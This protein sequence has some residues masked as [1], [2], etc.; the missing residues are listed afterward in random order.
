MIAHCAPQY[1]TKDIWR[2]SAPA[3]ILIACIIQVHSLVFVQTT[4]GKMI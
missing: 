2:V 3:L 1:T 4:A